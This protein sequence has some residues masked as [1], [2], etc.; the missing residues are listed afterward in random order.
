MTRVP[1]SLTSAAA[2]SCSRHDQWGLTIA[3]LG[4]DGGRQLPLPASGIG[5][6]AEMIQAI[7]DEVGAV[8][9]DRGRIVEVR[10]GR[11]LHQ[12]IGG[13][14]YTFR[15]ELG[16]M[17]PPETH[18]VLGAGDSRV[19]GTIVAV[20]DFDLLVHLQDDVGEAVPEA[21]I[22]TNAAFILE[23]LR[24]RLMAAAD[25][26]LGG[27]L[28]V[29]LAGVL[30]TT[31]SVGGG[32]DA[33]AA[34]EVQE[35]LRDLKDPAL[36]PND[37]QLTAMR[38]V[39][40]SSIHFVWGPPGTGKTAALAQMA[41]LL[42]DRGE[43]VLVLAHANVAVDV[44]MLRIADAFA[45][46]ATLAGGQIVRVGPAQHPEALRREEILLERL[47]ERRA[48]DL[49]LE[50]RHLEERRRMLAAEL[51]ASRDVVDRDELN[52]ELRTLRQRLATLGAELRQEETAV[53][54]AATVV[55]ATFARLVLS[56]RLWDLQPDAVLVDEASM[57]SFPWVLA[58]ATR[59]STRLVTL[60]DFRQLPPVQVAK[61]NL[62]RRW[63]ARD[64]FDVTGIRARI[65][66][67]DDDARMTML[68][69]QY[70]M[71]TPIGR[72]VSEL[73]YR[74]LLRTDESA[75][76]P[77][78][79]DEEPWPGESLIVVDTSELAPACR[80]ESPPF[81]FSRVNPVHVALALSI[82][83]L[84]DRSTAIITPYRAQARLLAAGVQDL[85]LEKAS[86]AT[87][88]R[89]QGSEREVVI[90]DLVDA[91]PLDSPS[92]LTGTDLDLA[93]R[94]VNVA[95]S[96][97]KAKAILLVHLELVR[98]RFAHTSPVRRAVELAA[99]DG[100]V[101]R[102]T[103]AGLATDFNGD[104]IEWL[105]PWDDVQQRLLADVTGART[106][107]LLNVPA[108]F[109]MRPSLAEVVAERAR[110]GVRLVAAGEHDF[111]ARFE[112]VPGE[113]RFLARPGFVATLDGSTAYLAGHERGTCARLVGPS[114]VGLL[115]RM[116]FEGIASSLPPED[117]ALG[118]EVD[119][120][121]APA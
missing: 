109:P 103:T 104:A 107:I 80:L 71:A 1:A 64:A 60:G 77:A 82:G 114:L 18:V 53:I 110:S 90:F 119:A 78:A 15:A 51:R 4:I 48:P 84:T 91:P 95:L 93:R 49:A 29:G 76:R 41:R 16:T 102:P 105:A 10:D 20:E 92:R 108:G 28:S 100:H 66:A 106:S 50:K 72:V 98:S 67:G 12:G 94:L 69:T 21:S 43:R 62:A 9:R 8:E 32:E 57:V 118:S 89:F 87:T 46:T 115:D 39:A 79:I 117:N 55:G 47:V 58:A 65:D 14:L 111:V 45:D 2:V 88:H 25:E 96:R 37:R 85:G 83:G 74:G 73:G 19:G 31:T 23:R 7:D 13:S 86:A 3:E 27:L 40:G 99:R 121:P 97:A 63:L 42:A 36:S 59:T 33:A 112:E 26:S 17:L 38:R 11:R 52:A 116:L 5:A 30:C 81:S 70:R 61:T 113:P 101:V 120:D 54:T 75:A 34:A 6:F 44:A 24:D 35:V 56:Q 22:S 68:D